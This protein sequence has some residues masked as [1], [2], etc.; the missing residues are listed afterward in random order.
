MTKVTI[1]AE[2]FARLRAL[3]ESVELCGPEGEVAGKFHPVVD[4]SGWEPVDPEISEEELDRRENS[5]EKRYTTAEAI[6]HLE[7]LK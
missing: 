1:D 3:N 5:N 6:S 4:L 7:S 2:L